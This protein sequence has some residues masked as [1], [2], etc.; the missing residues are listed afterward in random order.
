MIAGAPPY[1]MAEVGCSGNTPLCMLPTLQPAPDHCLHHTTGLSG[2]FLFRSNPCQFHV[3]LRQSISVLIS[4]FSVLISLL[5]KILAQ[6]HSH[7]QAEWPDT[8]RPKKYWLCRF[9]IAD[10]LFMEGIRCWSANPPRCPFPMK[11]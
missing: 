6:L 3:S 5:D 8:C 9:R 4:F 2:T 10:L 11:S 7:N 1:T